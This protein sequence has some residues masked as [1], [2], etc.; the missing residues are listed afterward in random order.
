MASESETGDTGSGASRTVH[1]R[2]LYLSELRLALRNNAGAYGY[3]V[4]ITGALAVLTAT[5]KSPTAGQ[6]FLFLL[7]AVLSFAVI[8]LLATRGFTRPIDDSEATKVIALGS[9]LS[10]V[11]VAA[12][13]GAA[14]LGAMVLP[15]TPAWLVGGFL[16]SL[17]Y[18]LVSALE[19]SLARRIQEVRRQD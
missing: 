15:K 1:P 9:S 2:K 7:G 5:Y 6:V 8:E 4:M 10:L 12:A 11:S 14:L 17:I 19:M 13:V 3:S 16:A 18:L